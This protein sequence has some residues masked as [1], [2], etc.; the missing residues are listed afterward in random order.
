MTSGSRS[1]TLRAST[2]PFG[3]DAEKAHH[4][5]PGEQGEQGT[6]DHAEQRR[7]S[8]KDTWRR[9]SE[10]QNADPFGDEGDEDGVKYRTLKWW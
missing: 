3:A 8:F 4:G 10:H 6:Y 1:P 9:R 2:D 5:V 7:D